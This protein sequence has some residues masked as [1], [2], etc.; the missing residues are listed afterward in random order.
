MSHGA[1]LLICVLGRRL[2]FGGFFCS[3]LVGG[4]FLLGA[5]FL[6]RCLLRG[7][8][9]ARI[10]GFIGGRLLGCGLLGRSRGAGC[11]YLKDF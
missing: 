10:V 6:G 2:L 1:L 11:A 4:G 8:C 9:V 3:R 7:F 5:S